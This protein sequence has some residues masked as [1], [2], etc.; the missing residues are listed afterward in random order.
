MTNHPP[1][2]PKHRYPLTVLEA[3]L[4][5]FGHVNHAK[6]LELLEEARW[7]LITHNGF[8]LKE[9]QKIGI[10]P[11]ILEVKI[12]FKR[13]LRLRQKIVIETE[14]LSY[15]RKIATVHQK[16]LNEDHKV[17]AQADIVLGLY[18]L[19]KRKLVTPIP[20]WLKAIGIDPAEYESKS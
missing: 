5:T 12:E 2:K 4:D 11:V 18:D 10:G 3:H 8:G 9:I 13:E 1:Q 6:Y 20:A 16:I 7:D 14:L 17:C 19:H 15:T